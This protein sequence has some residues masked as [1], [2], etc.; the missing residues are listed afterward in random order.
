MDSR[1][2]HETTDP[3]EAHVRILIV[4]PGTDADYPAGHLP[5]AIESR[6]AVMRELVAPG[7][8]VDVGALAPGSAGVHKPGGNSGKLALVATPMVARVQ[9]AEAE[10]YDAVVVYGTFDPGAEAARSF[11]GIPVVGT[12]RAG[13]LL[14]AT[15]GDRL[16]VLVYEQSLKTVALR[17]ARAYCLEHLIADVRAIDV[18]PTMMGPRVVQVRKRMIELSRAMIAERGAQVI[19]PMGLSMLPTTVLPAEVM[20]EIGAPVV[21]PLLA[22]VKLAET[23]VQMGLSQSPLAYPR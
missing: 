20:P 5:A 16:G 22:G 6:E 7:T 3:L 13:L 23:L 4:L 10:G 9:Q 18:P 15:L 8:T 1:L 2:C 21:D 19:L 12:G 11:V 17:T 14:A